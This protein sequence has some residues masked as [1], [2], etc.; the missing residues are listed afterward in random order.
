MR[1]KFY[2][3]ALTK[4]CT[5]KHPR[6]KMASLIV[7]GGAILSFGV[8]GF[9]RHR[10]AETTALK[11]AGTVNGA[12]LYVARKGGGISKPCPD[13]MYEI[14]SSGIKYVVYADRNGL[15]QR[16]KL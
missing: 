12:T 7:K 14:I 5:S 9:N 13:C 15:I 11:R 6:Q 1:I 3:L 4:A 16:I 8:N 2:N 10:H